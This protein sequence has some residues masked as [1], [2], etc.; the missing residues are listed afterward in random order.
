MVASA[1]LG[2]ATG[3]S[4]PIIVIHY[5][6]ASTAQ[7]VVR[8]LRDR[9]FFSCVSTFPAVPMNKPSLRFTVSR[10]NSLDEVRAMIDNLVEVSISLTPGVFG[11]TKPPPPMVEPMEEPMAS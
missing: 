2:V 5:D 7:S 4:T 8:A 9:G 11:Q 1:G 3:D 6:S 10:H